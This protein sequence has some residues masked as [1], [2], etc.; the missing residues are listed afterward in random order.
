MPVPL[1]LVQ[2]K[3]Q[4]LR[5]FRGA[6]FDGA[7]L[8]D[9]CRVAAGQFPAVDRDFAF[10]HMQPGMTARSERMRHAIASAQFAKPQVGILMNGNGAIAAGFAR[11]QA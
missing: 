5:G 2:V 7:L 3:Q 11:D 10:R 8:I 6:H 4:D 1:V 9:D